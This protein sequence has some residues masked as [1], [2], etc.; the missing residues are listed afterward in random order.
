[1]WRGAI[2]IGPMVNFALFAAAATIH[3]WMP[4]RQRCPK[5]FGKTTNSNHGYEWFPCD[6]CGAR[7]TVR[8]Y[9][10]RP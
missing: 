1:M 4:Q 9:K 2:T 5:C 7:G 10:L 3:F 8:R 6:H